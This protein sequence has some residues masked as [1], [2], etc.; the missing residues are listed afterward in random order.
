MIQVAII[1]HLRIKSG[2][3]DSVVPLS[4]KN[5]GKYRYVRGTTITP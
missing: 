5:K 4:D 3:L 1:P 2:H